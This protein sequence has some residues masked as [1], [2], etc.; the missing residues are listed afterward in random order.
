MDSSEASHSPPLQGVRVLSFG[1][2]V[3]G[4]IC[5]LLLAELGADVVKIES[6][7]LPEPLRAYDSSDGRQLFEPSGARTSAL[8]AGL[9][10][11]VRNICID[12]KEEEGRDTYRALV[13][14]SHVVIENL[15][16]GKMESWECSFAAL[17]R[18]NPQLVML[19]ISGYGRSGPL[20]DFRAY[21]SNISN[22]IGL[23]A[24]WAAD[25]IHC[26]FIAGISGAGAVVAGLA[27][28]DRGAP[29]VYID[30]AETEASAAIMAPL[31]VDYLANGRQY[32]VSPND[33]PGSFFSGAVRCLGVDA[34][35]AIELEDSGDWQAM[36]DHLGRSDLRLSDEAPTPERR[37]ALLDAVEGWALARTPFEAARA[38]QKV[39]LAAGPVQNSEDIWRDVQLR[40]R[41]AFVEI[42]HPDIGVIEY[43]NAPGR[44]S[45]TPAR[46]A[47]RAPRLGEHTRE[48]LGEWLGCSEAAARK[49]EV[50]GAT[51]Q[52]E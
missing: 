13:A 52:A 42:D 22:Y 24:A 36:C 34:W 19:S 38:L 4:N 9:T 37:H 51:W 32:G 45:E 1:S 29:G 3:A 2:Y 11:S 46:V 6:K 44:L 12:M 23:T 39:G 30:M 7:D 35:V 41:G 17:K 40:S 20:R 49:L 31:Y 8:F 33:V 26:D 21:A 43:P 48:V 5:A 50:K 25:G 28:V 10:R 15:V 47:R 18:N 27:A 16:A 14:R